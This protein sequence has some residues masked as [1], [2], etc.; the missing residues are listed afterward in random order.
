MLIL[1]VGSCGAC[2]SITSTT[3]ERSPTLP[4]QTAAYPITSSPRFTPRPY[5]SA[6]LL[7]VATD[8]SQPLLSAPNDPLLS[9]PTM[10]ASMSLPISNQFEI[11][12]RDNG[13]TFTYSVTSRFLVFLDQTRYPQREQV[14][15]PDGIASWVS[16]GMGLYHDELKLPSVG[17]E[18]VQ[19]GTCVIQV[20]DFKV[21]IRVVDLK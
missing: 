13:Q 12:L 1:G 7:S 6:T 14:C 9:T 4:A 16:N 15:K 3:P 17:F 18:A 11:T 21:I 10:T 8:S 19:R 5:P 2:S 20:N